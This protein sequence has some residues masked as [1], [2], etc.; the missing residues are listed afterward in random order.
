MKEEIKKNCDLC[1]EKAVIGF[2]ITAD[3]VFHSCEKHAKT[4]SD[5]IYPIGDKLSAYKLPELM[6]SLTHP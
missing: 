4:L 2:G 5:I 1:L 3:A 6:K